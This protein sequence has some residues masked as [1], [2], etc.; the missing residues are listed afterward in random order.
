MQ[1]KGIPVQES[2]RKIQCYVHWVATSAKQFLQES[3]P[4]TFCHVKE[5]HLKYKKQPFEESVPENA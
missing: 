3:T 5:S 4:E 2:M 1:K